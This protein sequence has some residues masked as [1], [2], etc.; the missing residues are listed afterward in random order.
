[1]MDA[2]EGVRML[3]IAVIFVQEWKMYTPLC[4][5]FLTYGRRLILFFG[6]GGL[7]STDIG[8]ACAA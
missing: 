3:A 7:S 5:D 8:L 6:A 2:T 4:V 1:M